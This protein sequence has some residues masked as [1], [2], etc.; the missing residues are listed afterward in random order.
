[1]ESAHIL[2]NNHRI[3]TKTRVSRMIYLV[4]MDLKTTIDWLIIATT[5]L[6]LPMNMMPGESSEI[7]ITSKIFATD[8]DDGYLFGS[9]IVMTKNFT[10]IG[11]PGANDGA[12]YVFDYDEASESFVQRQKL[13][14]TNSTSS[15]SFGTSVSYSHV[16]IPVNDTQN[17]NAYHN[18][19]FLAIG[20]PSDNFAGTDSGSAYIFECSCTNNTIS[21][22][23]SAKLVASDARSFSSFGYAVDI[24]G[25]WCVIGSNKDR[26]STSS[27][28]AYV[29]EYDS[30][31]ARDVWSEKEK[32]VASN[33]IISDR[34]GSSV[35][36]SDVNNNSFI[37][38]AA[39]SSNQV[40]I[41]KYSHMMDSWIEIEILGPNGGTGDTY[42]TSLAISDNYD[43]LFVG[44]VGH[45]CIFEFSQLDGWNQVSIINSTFADSNF[46]TSISVFGDNL[47]V[48]A[49]MDGDSDSSRAYLF[50]LERDGYT[51]NKTGTLI[52]FDGEKHDGF[53]ATV[54]IHNISTSSGIS[55]TFAMVS[56][57]SDDDHGSRSGSIY[58]IELGL[59]YVTM[60]LS[61]DYSYNTQIEVFGDDETLYF[62]NECDFVGN[63]PSILK[64]PYDYNCYIVTFLD[65]DDSVVNDKTDNHGSYEIS[66]NGQTGAIGGYYSNSET[67]VICNNTNHISYCIVPE[68]DNCKNNPNLYSSR[69]D[70]VVSM[71]S[72]KSVTSSN[73]NVNGFSETT[74]CNGEHSCNNVSFTFGAYNVIIICGGL[75]SCVS[76]SF[77]PSS[78]GVITVICSGIGTCNNIDT[79]GNEVYAYWYVV[80]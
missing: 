50:E 36:I 55:R 62:V 46:G 53:G 38:V 6:I 27:G 56:S 77:Y 1:M 63:D 60:S 4:R 28:A 78:S 61:K 10:L 68:S 17:T 21:F 32:L 57:V 73:I 16:A 69:Q 3:N 5:I 42:G 8:A 29:F 67:N 37:F 43:F 49:S 48:G 80:I 51:W 72:Y 20:D 12:L 39:P 70:S 45:V 74:Y 41:F 79:E 52:A 9:P 47:I 15:S 25:K 34:F 66:M 31:G 65:C 64:I 59:E 75:Y 13:N 14:P 2:T 35:A 33:G 30:N 76:S 7:P 11:A 24:L 44:A 40:Y 18:V 23:Q 22:K 54:G 71:K 26:V 58:I 19:N